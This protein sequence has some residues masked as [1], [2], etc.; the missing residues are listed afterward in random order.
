MLGLKLFWIMFF[1]SFVSEN[2]RRFHVKQSVI[3]QGANA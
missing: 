2:R 1:R 3:G